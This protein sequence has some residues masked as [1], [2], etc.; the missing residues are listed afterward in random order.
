[1]RSGIKISLCPGERDDERVSSGTSSAGVRRCVFGV[2]NSPTGREIVD[3]WRARVIFG[4]A[5]VVAVGRPT[6]RMEV[7]DVSAQ[8][9]GASGHAKEC[10]YEG[11]EYERGAFISSVLPTYAAN[12]TVLGPVRRE[13]AV[14]VATRSHRAR[15]IVLP[16]SILSWRAVRRRVP[17]L[18]ERERRDRRRRARRPRARPPRDVPSAGLPTD[19][20]ARSVAK[21]FFSIDAERALAIVFSASAFLVFVFVFVR[22]ARL[23]QHFQRRTNAPRLWMHTPPSPHHSC[24]RTRR[25]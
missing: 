22:R 19:A 11:V 5:R 16:L 1:M 24:D 6:E 18:D 3:A 4:S 9:P 13:R 15:G 7:R 20:H 12:A 17:R 2:R 8:N 21:S 10:S 25:V 14:R 23:N